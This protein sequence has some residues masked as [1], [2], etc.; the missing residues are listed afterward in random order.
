MKK[1]T[2]VLTIQHN[3]EITFFKEVKENADYRD[4]QDLIDEVATRGEEYMQEKRIDS[5]EI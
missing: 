1:T 4:V 3:G 2:V 5:E